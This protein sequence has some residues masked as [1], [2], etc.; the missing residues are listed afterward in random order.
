[1]VLGKFFC[2]ETD[3]AAKRNIL[4]PTEVLPKVYLGGLTAQE[5]QRM[6]MFLE[7]GVAFEHFS[8]TNV[9]VYEKLKLFSLKIRSVL[10]RCL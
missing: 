3:V 6:A 7:D 10:D 2:P 5:G 1:M 4:F 8:R 9:E